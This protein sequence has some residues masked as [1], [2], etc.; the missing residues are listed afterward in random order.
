MFWCLTM[1]KEPGNCDKWQLSRVHAIDALSALRPTRQLE[2]HTSALTSLTHAV[3][4]HVSKLEQERLPAEH[5]SCLPLALRINNYLEEVA[6]LAGEVVV[7]GEEIDAISQ[8]RLG[9]AV[10]AFTGQAIEVLRSCDSAAEA[11][12][13]DATASGYRQLRSAWH[14]LKS[15]LLTAASRGEIPISNLTNALD[16][17]RSTL[18]AVEQTTKVARRSRELRELLATPPT[19]A[20]AEEGNT[21]AAAVD[22]RT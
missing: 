1:K 15:N 22:P 14:D 20:D 3:E 11:F 12:D 8:G 19:A 7:H 13:L 6:Q 10:R 21:A 2:D 5:A 9:D 17:L 16:G 4:S 18:R